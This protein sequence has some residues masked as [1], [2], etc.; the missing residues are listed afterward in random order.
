MNTIQNNSIFQ[1]NDIS[2]YTSGYIFDLSTVVIT[3]HENMNTTTTPIMYLGRT[4]TSNSGYAELSI[5]QYETNNTQPRVKMEFNL[6]NTSAN[7]KTNVLTLT[8][9]DGGYVGINNNNPQHNLDVSGTIQLDGEI[10]FKTGS[11]IDF[12]GGVTTFNTPITVNDDISINSTFN[13]NHDTSFN[14]NVDIGDNLVIHKEF[15]LFENYTD[16]FTGNNSTIQKYGKIEYKN[17]TTT[18]KIMYILKM[19]KA[20][21]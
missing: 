11:N 7:D 5:C 14:N 6:D 8:A 12:K 2:G 4:G 10:E 20:V 13:I 1:I 15:R 16:K 21:I 19:L 18:T 3:K 9:K 17:D